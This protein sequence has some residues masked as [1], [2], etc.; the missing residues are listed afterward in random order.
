M[1]QTIQET[2]IEQ[3]LN[4]TAI[5]YGYSSIDSAISYA[6]EPIVQKFQLEGVALR[7]WRSL[8]WESFYN[9]INLININNEDVNNININDIIEQLPKCQLD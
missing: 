6:A 2:Q 5:S 8:V 1:P 3:F 9:Y 7:Q 4:E